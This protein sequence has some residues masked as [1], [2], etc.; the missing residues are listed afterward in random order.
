M[1]RRVF[2]DTNEWIGGLSTRSGKAAVTLRNLILDGSVRPVTCQR[3]IR[4]A[5]IVIAQSPRMDPMRHGYALLLLLHDLLLPNRTKADMVPDPDKAQV[6][7]ARSRV[8]DPEYAWWLVLAEREHVEI[9]SEDRHLHDAQ[10]DRRVWTA[11]A[12][13]AD[14]AETL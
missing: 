5:L 14:L 4:Q 7:A 10:T 12:F 3:Q 1:T 2:L 13:L 9:I 6:L 11:Q 8:P